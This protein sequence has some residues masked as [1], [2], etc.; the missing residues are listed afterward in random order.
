MEIFGRQVGA[1]EKRNKILQNCRL[2]VYT[3]ADVWNIL[4]ELDLLPQFRFKCYEVL[5]NNI[6]RRS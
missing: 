1:I 4:A 5:C 2:R 6:K 3:G